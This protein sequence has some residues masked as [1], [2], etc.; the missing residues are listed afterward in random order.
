M[1]SVDTEDARLNKELCET[2][3]LN[4]SIPPNPAQAGWL[5]A[6]QFIKLG[7]VG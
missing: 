2:V 4:E 6:A 1:R 7:A 5:I 3:N